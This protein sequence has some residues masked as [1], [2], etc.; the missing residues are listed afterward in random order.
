MHRYRDSNEF[1]RTLCMENL[2]TS[3]VLRPSLFLQDKY[4]KYFGW[5]LSDSSAE[6]RR[7]ALVAL[8]LPFDTLKQRIENGSDDG[9]I[10]LS[11][12][13]TWRPQPPARTVAPST[14]T[15]SPPR[16]DSPPLP[17]PRGLPR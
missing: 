4:L 17:P 6:V 15:S 16:H 3:I 13:S 10:D 14:S 2:S 7:S 9:S 11:A 12:S 5:M 8:N 1:I